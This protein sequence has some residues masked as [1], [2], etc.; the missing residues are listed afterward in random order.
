MD[1][2]KELL[3][4]FL[5][6]SCGAACADTVTSTS[7]LFSASFPCPAVAKVV[8]STS[9]MEKREYN[10]AHGDATYSVSEIVATAKGKEYAAK[11]PAVDMVGSF[12]TDSL[13]M[14]KKIA[15]QATSRHGT[16]KSFKFA[17]VDAT[18]KGN[19]HVTVMHVHRAI[20]DSPNATINFKVTGMDSAAK[21][22]KAAGDSFKI[23]K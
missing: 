10:C 6:F 16:E 9:T 8:S 21:E 1:V 19:D 12:E 2:M 18:G 4:L 14:Y 22:I 11:H 23:L 5:A 3:P 15:W 20:Y 7:G 17:V 13:N